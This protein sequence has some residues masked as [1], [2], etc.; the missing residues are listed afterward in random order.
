MD[1]EITVKNY[2][3]FSDDSPVTITIG[4]GFTALVGPNNCGKSSLLKLFIELRNLWSQIG[5]LGA[6]TDF[7]RGNNR[8]AG[9]AEVYDARE[10]FCD[11]NTRPIHT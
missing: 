1:L 9:L 3:C 11:S 8:G 6:F 5:D 10:I 7:F 4:K 2:R